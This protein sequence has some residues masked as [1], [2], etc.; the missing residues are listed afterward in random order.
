MPIFQVLGLPYVTP[1]SARHAFISTLQS[2]GIE[3]GLVAKLAGHADPA[4]TLDHYTQA[5]RGGEVAMKAL[6]EAYGALALEIPSFAERH[7]T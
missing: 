7:R 3:I 5:V 6:E 2:R 4:V 1:H